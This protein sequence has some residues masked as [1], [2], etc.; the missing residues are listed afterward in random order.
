MKGILTITRL[1][2]R[3]DGVAD[4]PAGSVYVAGAL[5]GETVEVEHAGDRARLT[6]I[7]SA[8][9]DRVAPLCPHFGRCG[10]C[11]AQ[12]MAP[13]LY[14]GWKLGILREAL[15]HQA[16]EAE[17]S[18]LFSVP[19]ESRRRVTLALA[20]TGH[21]AVLGFHA[22]RSS[23]IVPIATCHVAERRIVQ[24]LPALTTLL[25]PLASA[26]GAVHVTVLAT[27]SGL[28]VDVAAPRPPLAAT[29]VQGASALG[30]ARLSLSD[31]ALATFRAP[32]LDVEGVALTPPPGGFVQAVAVAEQALAAEVSNIIAKAKHIA[33]LFAGAGAFSLRLARQARV[34]AVEADASALAS[35]DAARRSASGL[36]PLT[37]ERRDLFRRPL[38]PVEL[39]PFDAV[40][41]DPPRQGA[42]AQ[43]AALAASRVKTIAYVS[44]AP[45]TFARDARVLVDAGFKLGR[46]LP[47]DQFLW[48][49]HLE[50][51][52][53]FRR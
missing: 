52:A 33:D 31:E 45:A 18:D 49:A 34:H 43:I 35:L 30:L 24:A 38:Q 47:V 50:V 5:P 11:Q 9:P 20:R 48:S 44:C 39:E 28:D 51:V 17:I 1:G 40:V 3:G 27:A 36:K 14:Q 2:H 41:L 22:A 42:A 10:G 8:S 46:I 15:A 12:H 29:L 7:V 16:L 6:R 25:A 21:G 13:D 19:Q 37:M 32:L 53:G 23:D 4:G 26:K